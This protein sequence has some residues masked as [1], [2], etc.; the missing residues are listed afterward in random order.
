MRYI[1]FRKIPGYSSYAVSQNGVIVSYP[2]GS[3]VKQYLLNGYAIVDAFY[4]SPTETLPVHRAVALAWVSNPDPELNTIVNHLDG[5]KLNNF[6]GNLEWT[7]YSGNNYHAVNT[8]LRSDNICCRI[9][10]FETKEVLNFSSI[11]QASFYM[12]LSKDA[13][14]CML[15]RKQFG[16]LI[17]NRF[18]F[19]FEKDDTPWFYENRSQRVG[20]TRYMVEV[21]DLNNIIVHEVFSNRNM[22]KY[23]QLYDS[24]YGKSISG[25]VKYANEKYPDKVF[26]LRDSYT[27][28]RN[29][30]R[31]TTRRIPPIK[32][33]ASDNSEII[34]FP[35]LTATAKHFNVDRKSIINRLDCDKQLDGWSFTKLAA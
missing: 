4:N 10:D 12:G 31:T 33:Q 27:E 14:S 8:G 21:R 23:Y 35:S 32:I 19:K 28:E 2:N 13:P 24:P 30:V 16:A 20:P 3:I 7:T 34:D 11:S 17:K 6:F 9:R 22:L 18:E 29:R 1:E 15:L 25:L 26:A 5:N